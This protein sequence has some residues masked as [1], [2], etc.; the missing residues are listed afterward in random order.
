MLEIMKNDNERWNLLLEGCSRLEWKM[1]PR[2]WFIIYKDG[3][4]VK[5][6][7]GEGLCE[8]NNLFKTT[9]PTTQVQAAGTEYNCIHTVE[10]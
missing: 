9:N 4:L 5:M 1:T 10:L 3:T 6:I 8:L 7:Q 2:Q